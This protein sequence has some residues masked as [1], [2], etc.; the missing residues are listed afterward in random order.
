[1]RKKAVTYKG[2]PFFKK[3]LIFQQTLCTGQNDVELYQSADE[4]KILQSRIFYLARLSFRVEGEI[5]SLT[6][7]QNLKEYATTYTGITKK[8]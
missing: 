2:T 8:N 5:N 6:D 4:K 1:M 3:K 7:K